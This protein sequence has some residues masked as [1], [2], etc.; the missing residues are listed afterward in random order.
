MAFQPETNPEDAEEIACFLRGLSDAKLNQAIGSI[1]ALVGQLPGFDIYHLRSE[2]EGVVRQLAIAELE[3]RQREHAES[4]V[5]KQ[6]EAANRQL[7][8]AESVRWATILAAIATE[9]MTVARA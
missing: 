7:A 8:A 5:N 2:A 4:L 9:L 3:R 6:I 1:R